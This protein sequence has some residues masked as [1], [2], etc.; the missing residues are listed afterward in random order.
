MPV[1]RNLHANESGRLRSRASA[2]LRLLR[3]IVALVLSERYVVRG[4]SMRPSLRPGQRLLVR[5][6][7][8]AW[9]RGQVVVVRDPR[10]PATR[11][12]KR[13]VGLPGEEVRLLDG[14]LLVDGEVLEEPYLGGLPS[15]LGPGDRAWALGED[16]YL[17]LGDNRSRST[18]SRGFGPVAAE[19]IAGR[20]WF[21]YW[22]PRA[23]GR[24]RPASRRSPSR[25]R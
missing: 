11:F 16:E 13:L 1:D 19:L 14:V 21:R 23:W 2:A 17:V 10:E 7:G 5:R 12:M 24:I 6:T 9:S 15:S 18:D 8:L 22:P 25:G 4:D 3:R 20:V